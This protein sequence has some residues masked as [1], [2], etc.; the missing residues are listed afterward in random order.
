MRICTQQNLLVCKICK[1]P[2]HRNNIRLS[3]KGLKVLKQR[4]SLIKTVQINSVRKYCLKYSICNK[5]SSHA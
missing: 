1:V 4:F 2:P 5:D 3:F